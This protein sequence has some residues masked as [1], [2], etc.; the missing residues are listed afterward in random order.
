MARN[1]TADIARR[2]QAIYLGLIATLN[3][4]QAQ[5]ALS[6]WDTE[7]AQDRS[8]AIIDYVSEIATVLDLPP[9]VRHEVRMGLY[10]AL[11]KYDAG[12]G[13][14]GLDASQSIPASGAA[15]AS[16]SASQGPPHWVVFS[17]VINHL[18]EGVQIDGAVSAQDFT[19]SLQQ[20]A[21]TSKLAAEDHAAMV[22]WSRGDTQTTV[23]LK[24]REDDMARMVHTIYVAMAE[25]LG[26]VAAD[27]LLAGAVTAAEALPEARLFPARRF[28]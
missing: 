2:R 18:R 9:K 16:G 26:P 27:R 12:R 5:Q 21:R 23:F 17:F 15:T 13:T 19:Y 8:T 1:T 20:Q 7:Y 4:Q 11:L 25:S 3:E 24:L 28:L 14:T 10:Q 22:S 6:I